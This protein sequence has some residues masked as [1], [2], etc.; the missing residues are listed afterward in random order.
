[1]AEETDFW[2]PINKVEAKVD[3]A[4]AIGVK[5]DTC[6]PCIDGFYEMAEETDFW[7][8]I[9]KVEAKVDEA[10]AIK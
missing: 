7:S 5:A 3:E 6:A 9:N 4:R 1:M 2:S 10:R 8:P